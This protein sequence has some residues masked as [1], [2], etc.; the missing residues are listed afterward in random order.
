MSNF[1]PKQYISQIKGKDYLE[2]RYR[3]LWFRDEHKAGSIQTERISENP[4]V[5][6]ASIYSS[7]GV[8]LAQGH[9]TAIEKG[10][11]VWK[12][13]AVEKA[14]TA[15]IGRALGHAGYGTQFAVEGEPDDDSEAN[16]LA[17]SPHKSNAQPKSQ[18]SKPAQ[19][20]PLETPPPA[21]DDATGATFQ[22][23]IVSELALDS[24][25]DVLEAF[26]VAYGDPVS[27]ILKV[28]EWPYGVPEAISACI[29]YKCGYEAARINAFIENAKKAGTFKNSQKVA[30]TPAYLESYRTLALKL[31]K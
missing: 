1:D 16:H 13:R 18:P 19:Q 29:A 26:T 31:A 8:L 25:K 11:E 7:D 24:G 9:A 23:W 5:F 17:D 15:A 21:F 22:N 10:G 28:S 14:E 3:I 20:K 30:F 27:N 6:R 12:G 4:P 2:T